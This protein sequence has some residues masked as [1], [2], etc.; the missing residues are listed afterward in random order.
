M[1]NDMVLFNLHDK[2]QE[3]ELMIIW[4][5]GKIFSLDRFPINKSGD[6]NKIKILLLFLLLLWFFLAYLLSTL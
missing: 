1:I 4:E 6:K 5:L 2:R 3:N